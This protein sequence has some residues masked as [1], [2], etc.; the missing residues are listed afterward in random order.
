MR[1]VRAG[2]A[3][4]VLLGAAACVSPSGEH[5]SAPGH[6]AVAGPAEVGRPVSVGGPWLC[7]NGSVTVRLVSVEPVVT[8]GR[9]DL[10]AAVHRIDTSAPTDLVGGGDDPL[11]G[12]YRPVAGVDVPACSSTARLVLGVEA[13][14]LTAASAAVAGLRIGYRVAGKDHHTDADMNLGLCGAQGAMDW[15]GTLRSMDC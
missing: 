13:T 10:R 6:V 15:P 14:R 11:P 2:A 1:T 12:S 8:I 3:G 9:L 4:L 5:L 7:S